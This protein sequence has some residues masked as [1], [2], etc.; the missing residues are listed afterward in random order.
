MKRQYLLCFGASGTPFLDAFLTVSTGFL[1]INLT[2]EFN[3]NSWESGAFGTSY[4][5][6][7][8]LG[9]FV[10]GTLGRKLWTERLYYLCPL[11]ILLLSIAQSFSDSFSFLLALRFAIGFFIGIDYP[12]SQVFFSTK[13]DVSFKARGLTLLMSSWYW[14]AIFSVLVFWIANLLTVPNSYLLGSSAVISFVVLS[15]R[16]LF[17]RNRVKTPKNTPQADP[18]TLPTIH[19]S[20]KYLFNLGFLCLFWTIQCIP[21]TVLLLFGPSLMMAL[22]IQGDNTYLQLAGTYAFFFIG[23]CVS[24]LLINHIT[25]KSLALIT[26]AAMSAFL[27]PLIWAA[28]LPTYVALTSFICYAG[29]YGLQTTLNYVYPNEIFPVQIRGQA[30]GIITCITRFIAGISSFFFPY[31]LY[32]FSIGSIVTAAVFILILGFVSTFFLAPSEN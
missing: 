23:S 29:A 18:T 11:V 6:G 19:W 10:L 14:G 12:I 32:S 21:V 1:L 24:Y 7:V 15:A 25:R 2:S 27:F 4:I 20:N 31:F 5:F 17:I 8:M 28:D 3:L 9:S 22:G 16:L 30:I 26:F 13:C